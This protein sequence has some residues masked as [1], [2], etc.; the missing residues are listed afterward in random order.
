VAL[1][2]A[3]GLLGRAFAPAD[4]LIIGDSLED[5]R[6]ARHCGVPLVAVATGW[7]PAERLRAAGAER[8]VASLEEALPFLLPAPALLGNP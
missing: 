8:V 3:A 1:S 6:C 4:A 2:R 7:T 5:V